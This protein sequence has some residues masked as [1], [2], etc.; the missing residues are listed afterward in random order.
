[1]ITA[2][3][4]VLRTYQTECVAAM[5]RAMAE[6]SDSPLAILPTATGKSL[7]IGQFTTD[8]LADDPTARIAIVTHVKELIAQN[9]RA[10]LSLWPDAPCGILSAGLGRREMDAQILL[11][12]IQSAYRHAEDI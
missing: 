1:M 7:I 8:V 6:T 12:S 2:I 11:A 5:H 10:L 9:C 3:P 4:P